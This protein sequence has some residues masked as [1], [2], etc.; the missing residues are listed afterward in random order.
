MA[1]APHDDR[2]VAPTDGGRTRCRGG[3]WTTPHREGVQDPDER[4]PPMKI[5]LIIL[6]VLAIVFLAQMVLR[7]R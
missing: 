1:R 7:K 5:L 3:P 2:G 4:L 6:V